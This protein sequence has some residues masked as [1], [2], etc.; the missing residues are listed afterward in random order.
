M[1][2]IIDLVTATHSAAVLDLLIMM[3]LVRRELLRRERPYQQD[4]TSVVSPVL[5]SVR[6]A[7]RDI[8]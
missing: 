6:M 1:L 4:H 7:K 5:A 8:A 2:S 3:G